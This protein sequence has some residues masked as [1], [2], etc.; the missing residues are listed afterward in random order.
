MI[1]M[2]DGP[3]TLSAD[4]GAAVG[5]SSARR[6]SKPVRDTFPTGDQP[7]GGDVDFEV[8]ASGLGFVEGPVVRPG[9]DVV[10]ASIT[11]GALFQISPD[12]TMRAR[13]ETG[14]GPNG[15]A[16]DAE[17]VLYVAQN[18]GIWGGK[19]GCPAGIQRVVGDLV[20]PL[21]TE[22]LEAPNDLCFGP[23]G[24]LY[25]T[26]P[27]GESAPP[28]PSTA[29]P[30]RLFSC[31][32]DGTDLRLVLE[33]P[34]FINGLAFTPEDDALYVVETSLPHRVLRAPWSSAGLGELVE[35]YRLEAGFP[36]GTAVDTDGNLWVAATFD[37]S[38]HVV[39][40]DG[41]L[42]RKLSC[43]EGALPTNCC[44]GGSNRSTLYVAAS[45]AGA[46]LHSQVDARGVALHTGVT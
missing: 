32:R 45:G 15:L 18:G 43:G 12:G 26:D 27:R 10:V 33:G 11:E 36:D 19:S 2:A 24:R 31:E 39:S 16:L 29:K 44:F 7:Q 4:E 37:D 8:L 34:R 6:S 38:I 21:V 17:D 40:P 41:R 22:G 46:V 13:I 1:A 28:D 14:G 5:R 35:V 20:E 23:D 25:F 3:I 9:G 30:G 42:S